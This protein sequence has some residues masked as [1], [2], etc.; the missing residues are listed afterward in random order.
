MIKKIRDKEVHTCDLKV[1]EYLNA[2]GL[3]TAVGGVM[4]VSKVVYPT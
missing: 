3:I 4:K 1:D 2:S